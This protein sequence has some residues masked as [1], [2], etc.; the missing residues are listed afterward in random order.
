MF[1]QDRNTLLVIRGL[2]YG[3]KEKHLRAAFSK[4]GEV[5]IV[6][7]R[8]YITKK[9]R[10]FAFLTFDTVKNAQ[11]AFT[12]MNMQK[13]GRPPAPIEV[14]LPIL[15]QTYLCHVHRSYGVIR[16]EHNLRLSKSIS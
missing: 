5:K 3:T 2:R 15:D 11:T 12:A 9:P 6:L 16:D 8:D 13:I 14:C 4:F 10:E 1:G 7:P